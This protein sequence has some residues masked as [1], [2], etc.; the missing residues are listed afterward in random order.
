LLFTE[1]LLTYAT[2][3]AFY[4]HLVSKENYVRRPTLLKSHPILSRLLTLKESLSTLEDLDFDMSDSEDVDELSSNDDDD[5]D[6]M[7]DT[8]LP[9]QLAKLKGLEAH[10]LEELLQ[11]A[12]SLSSSNK[13]ETPPKKKRKTTV[14]KKLKPVKPSLPVFDL[15]E[16]TFQSS[17]QTL[18]A[19]PDLLAADAYGEAT[20]LQH[21][22]AVDKSTRK[23]SLRFHTSRIEST[24]SRRQGTRNNAVGGDDDLPYRERVK[25]KARLAR[26]T[27][28]RGQGG[29]D[30]DDVE[31]ELV[32]ATR[33]EN[34]AADS[35]GE[36]TD[37]YYELV[38]RK[39]KVRKETK[40]AEYEASQAASR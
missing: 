4:L 26:E 29:E 12:Q 37:A 6:A 17:R 5:G 21:V 11:D 16:P 19:Q 28:V 40:Q 25:E 7:T 15:V 33:M 3:L 31:P 2:T 20:S 34:N 18:S 1:T 9:W 30:L 8:E 38:K 23:K 36:G 10:E 24:R 13:D 27:K 39:S 22:D 32:V 14:T 35:D